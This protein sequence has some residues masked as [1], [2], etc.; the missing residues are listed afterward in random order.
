MFVLPSVV[1]LLI[2]FVYF[3]GCLFVSLFDLLCGRFFF[4]FFFFFFFV[5]LFV[6]W[7]ACLLD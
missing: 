4:F 5:G 7:L 1:L 2:V 3:V 6:C